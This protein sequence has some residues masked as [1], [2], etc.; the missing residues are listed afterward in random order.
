MNKIKGHA[1]KFALAGALA[2][3]VSAVPL[4]L[5]AEQT[6][7]TYVAQVE[8]ICKANTQANETILKGVRAKVSHGELNSAA[9]QVTKAARALKK[10]LNQL[11]AVPQPS[12][13]K[14]KLGKWLGYI[15]TEVGL[16]EKTAKKLRAGDTVGA[17]RTSLYLSRESNRANNLVFSFEFHYCHAEPSK[18]L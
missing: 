10:T 8:P 11:R 17:E 2:L 4:A 7:E 1:M 13:D 15:K 5:G 14:A 12:A 9:V 16:F 18:F 3:I 6:R